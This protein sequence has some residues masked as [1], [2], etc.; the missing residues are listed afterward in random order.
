MWSPRKRRARNNTG[1]RSCAL[2]IVWLTSVLAPLALVAHAAEGSGTG[3]FSFVLENDLFYN[4]DRNYTNGVQIVWVPRVD[5][6][7]DWAVRAAR[8]IP[9]FPQRGPRPSWLCAG[10]EHVYAV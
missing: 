2:A 9:W 4:T 8:Q 1:A 6:P 7:P 3:T 5:S 10:P